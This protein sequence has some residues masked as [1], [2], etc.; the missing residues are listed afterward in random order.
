MTFIGTKDGAVRE[1]GDPV[2]VILNFTGPVI[3]GMMAK[4]LFSQATL[5]QER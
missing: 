5:F 4:V 3:K 2:E 1:C